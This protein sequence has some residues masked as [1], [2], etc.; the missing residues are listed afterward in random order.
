MAL[1]KL[2]CT[3]QAE[4]AGWNAMWCIVYA[5]NAVSESMGQ[6]PSIPNLLNLESF[7]SHLAK[8]IPQHRSQLCKALHRVC[9]AI[10]EDGHHAKAQSI[11]K[12]FVS[13]FKRV[14]TLNN[15]SEGDHS[16]SNMHVELNLLTKLLQMSERQQRVEQ[17]MYTHAKLRCRLS[18]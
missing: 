8:V 3:S 9:Q 4:V 6:Q 15:A 12:K 7:P 13:V 16:Q 11:I 2:S 10:L 1:L 14:F 17:K 18:C 5:T